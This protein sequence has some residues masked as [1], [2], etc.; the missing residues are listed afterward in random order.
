MHISPPRKFFYSPYKLTVEFWN[1]E[2]SQEKVINGTGF[3]IDLPDGF[4]ALVTNRHVLDIRWMD[5]IMKYRGF[6]LR[7]ILVSARNSH[8]EIYRFK[9]D[10]AVH[11]DVTY[12]CFSENTLNDVAVLFRPYI[13]GLDSLPNK[14]IHFHFGQE[15]LADAEYFKNELDPLDV[16]SFSGFPEEHDIVSDRP[17]TRSGE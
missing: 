11:N 13:I 10:G 17:V 4:P 2:M 14:K 12:V 6:N 5:K 3:M 7:T 1:P 15:S 16:V 9:I 8:N